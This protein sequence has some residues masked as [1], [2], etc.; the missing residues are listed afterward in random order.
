M[1]S[2]CELLSRVRAAKGQ[3]AAIGVPPKDNRPR[4]DYAG[5]LWVSQTAYVLIRFLPPEGVL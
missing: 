5:A 3:T 1:T 2:Q 4:Y